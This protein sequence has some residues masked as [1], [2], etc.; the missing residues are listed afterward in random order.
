MDAQIGLETS[1]AEQ[2]VAAAVAHDE[3]A[4]AG[5]AVSGTGGGYHRRQHSRAA[6]SRSVFQQG[7]E[8]RI[9]PN[10]ELLLPGHTAV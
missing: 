6:I 7:F 1:A 10:V 5:F 4:R 9:E 3:H 8:A 2:A